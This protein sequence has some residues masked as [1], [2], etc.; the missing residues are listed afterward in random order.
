MDD[1][2]TCVDEHGR[3][4]HRTEYPH[5]V[6]VDG[7]RGGREVIEGTGFE[8]WILVGYHYG[9]GMSVDEIVDD[10]DYLTPAAV[11]SA[12]AYYHEHREEI[13]QQRYENSYEYW[14]E[15]SAKETAIANA[16]TERAATA[17]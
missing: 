6:R 17:S 2:Q 9:A 15:Q 8:V 1:Q 14:K 10:W 12:L 3:T 11:H 5:I 16:S 7:L 4:V 13:E